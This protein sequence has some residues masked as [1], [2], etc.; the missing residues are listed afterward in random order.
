MR[1]LLAVGLLLLAGCGADERH[2]TPLIDI[3]IRPTDYAIDGRKASYVQVRD[4][5]ARIAKENR[6][7]HT[8]TA[9]AIIR[10]RLLPG[11]GE[12]RVQELTEHCLAVGLAVIEVV[13]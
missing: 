9:R 12:E 10:M 13:R 1:R 7:E 11:A 5:L 2:P 4:D 3:E 6:R 8:G